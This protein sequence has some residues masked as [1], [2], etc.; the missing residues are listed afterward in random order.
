MVTLEPCGCWFHLACHYKAV[1]A[2]NRGA[3][4]D[5]QCGARVQA[6]TVSPVLTGAHTELTTV[7]ISFDAVSAAVSAESVSIGTSAI[8]TYL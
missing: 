2:G 3:C 6:S 5:R 1:L 7:P 4:P 8:E